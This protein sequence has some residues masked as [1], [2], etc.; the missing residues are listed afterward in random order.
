MPGRTAG[1]KIYVGNL[2][3]SV[4]Q[5]ELRKLFEEHGTVTSCERGGDQFAFVVSICK[6]FVFKPFNIIFFGS[7]KYLFPDDITQRERWG[8]FEMPLLN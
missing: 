2:H 6:Y 5:S 8:G 4:T 3:S 1:T 7:K